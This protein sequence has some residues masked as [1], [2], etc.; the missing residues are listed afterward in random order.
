[1]LPQNDAEHS[2]WLR[3]V[4][5]PG[6]ATLVLL[7]VGLT[8]CMEGADCPNYLG[9]ARALCRGDLLLEGPDLSPTGAIV[10]HHAIGPGLTWLPFVWIARLCGRW[11][12]SVAQQL[13]YAYAAHVLHAV[14]LVVLLWRVL[15]HAGVNRFVATASLAF[16]G[17]GSPLFYYAFLAPSSELLAAL[18]VFGLFAWVY[19]R[20]T[21]EGQWRFYTCSGLLAG[22]ALAVRGNN[23]LLVAPVLCLL[24]IRAL[25]AAP[26]RQ[27]AAQC[28]LMGGAFGLVAAPWFITN[29]LFLGSPIRTPVSY[30]LPSGRQV[31]FDWSHLHLREVL[32]SH[33]HGL[34][35]YSP[36][37]L[38]ALVGLVWRLRDATRRPGW[39]RLRGGSLR[40]WLGMSLAIGF[41]AQVGLFSAWRCWWMGTN[42]FG[43]R[44]FIQ[45]MPF[46]VLGAAFLLRRVKVASVAH[47]VAIVGLLCALWGH[48]FYYH[49]FGHS[50]FCKS[51][52]HIWQAH[53]QALAQRPWLYVGLA[54]IVSIGAIA[55]RR[56]KAQCWLAV[57]ACV[58]LAASIF[59]TYARR[60]G[61]GAAW[62]DRGA[63]SLLTIACAGAVLAF[64]RLAERRPNVALWAVLTLAVCTTGFVASAAAKTRQRIASEPPRPHEYPGTFQVKEW[65]LTYLEYR[66][67]PGHEQEKAEYRSAIREY[68]ELSGVEIDELHPLRIKPRGDRSGDGP[69]RP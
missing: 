6:V 33:W 58:L 24:A 4:V 48:L 10:D 31:W 14:L 5:L 26:W 34:F 39:W 40:D 41:A 23:L 53:V 7:Q 63:L 27:A 16:V 3:R 2:T 64:M 38:L 43:G 54:C 9:Y 30:R 52:L 12:Q 32:L 68:G 49:K 18:T 35:V 55:R 11:G 57:M 56:E 60:P 69:A 29:W 37:L 62:A 59:A 1:M 15:C 61:A 46:A 65:L 51:Y 13:P 28:A 67:I 50:N 20:S 47:P 17:F 21:D 45:A 44:Q 42:T 66:F 19:I 25:A 36:I 8:C 22:A